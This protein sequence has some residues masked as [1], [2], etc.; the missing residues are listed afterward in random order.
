MSPQ[1]YL[2]EPHVG[3]RGSAESTDWTTKTTKD[4]FSTASSFAG[5][6]AEKVKEAASQTAAT[7]TSEVKQLLDRQV[8][9]GAQMLGSVARSA[10]RAAEDLERDSPQVAGLVRAFASRIDGYA[11]DLRGQSFDQVIKTASDFTRGQPALVFGLAAL[12]GFFALRTF[13]SSPSM[14]SPSIQ[15]HTDVYSSGRSKLS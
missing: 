8:G 10:N 15:P 13:K 6:A 1:D 4:A 14:S 12:A 5:Q 2:R 9:G 11:N 3:P 7:V